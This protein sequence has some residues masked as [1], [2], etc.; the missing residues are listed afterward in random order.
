MAG[1]PRRSLAHAQPRGAI[2]GA[3]NAAHNALFEGAAGVQL[4]YVHDGVEWW[5]TLMRTERGA[6]LVRMEAPRR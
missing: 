2:A 6:R 1:C 3:L 5:D 4:R